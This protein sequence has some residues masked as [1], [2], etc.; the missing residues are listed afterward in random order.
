MNT[1]QIFSSLAAELAYNILLKA[2]VDLLLLHHVDLRVLYVPG[3]NNTVAF[4]LAYSLI[5]GLEITTFQPPQCV[6]G[7]AQK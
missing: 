6:M 4:I 1:V 3:V 7:A 5:P 2:A